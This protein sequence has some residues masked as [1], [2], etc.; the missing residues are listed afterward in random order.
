[1][2]N[3]ERARLKVQYEICIYRCQL[4]KHL[5]NSYEEEA[6]KLKDLII[7]IDKKEGYNG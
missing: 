2:A 4:Y 6:I 3:N 1:M 5:S 7:E